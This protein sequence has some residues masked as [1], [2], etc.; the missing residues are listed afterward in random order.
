MA[1]VCS[2][3]T[4]AVLFRRNLNCSSPPLS[5]IVPRVSQPARTLASGSPA[6][7]SYFS[8]RDVRHARVA[9]KAAAGGASVAQAPL[10]EEV[11]NPRP[12]LLQE[13][14]SIKDAVHTMLDANIA[15]A[16]VVNKAGQIVGVLTEADVIWK[17][18]GKPED[19]FIIPPVF[20][21]A[22][23]AYVFLRD[24]KAFEEETHKILARTVKDAMVGKDKVVTV[25]PGAAMSEAA[26][27]MVHNDVNLLPVV[28][29]SGN[30]VG[31]VTRH[32]ILR[33]LYASDNPLL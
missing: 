30:V 16:P 7:I 6:H 12:V 31:I 21:G 28:E 14:M 5:S 11:M 26:Q 4:Q 22:L 20:I 8:E 25:K 2:S 27:L 24:N 15:G 29:A 10:V 9:A 23:D 33:G 13:D 17:G 19:H 32:D 18:A 3:S 1:V